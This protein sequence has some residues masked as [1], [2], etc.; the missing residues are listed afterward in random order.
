[1]AVV[2]CP[3]CKGKGEVVDVDWF[4]AVVTLGLSFLSDVSTPM[5]C[6][7]CNGKGFVDTDRMRGV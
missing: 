6:P 1:M 2:V 3:R 4:A 7:I 5:T